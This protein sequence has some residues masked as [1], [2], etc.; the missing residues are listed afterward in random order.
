MHKTIYRLDDAAFRR[1]R[2]YESPSVSACNMSNQEH[3]GT[4][5]QE[6]VPMAQEIEPNSH[7]IEVCQNENKYKRIQID[8]NEISTVFGKRMHKR[9]VETVK[10]EEKQKVSL[11]FNVEKEI[12]KESN[13][14]NGPRSNVNKNSG[15]I[16]SAGNTIQKKLKHA[17][18][19]D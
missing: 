3:D 6:N 7:Q 1:H 5:K 19:I 17:I 14:E 12:A 16:S 10:E 15:T 13:K 9:N 11:R 18:K 8:I 4:T 2:T